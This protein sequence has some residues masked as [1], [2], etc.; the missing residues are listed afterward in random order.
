MIPL[1]AIMRDYSTIISDYFY[2]YFT[3]IFPIITDYTRLFLRL[4]PIISGRLHPK[5]GNVPTAILDP[6]TE[7]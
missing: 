3:I 4:F 2:D 5:D 6:I 7:E 1:Y